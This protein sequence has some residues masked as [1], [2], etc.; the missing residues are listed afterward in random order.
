MCVREFAYLQPALFSL[1]VDY[2]L[3]CKFWS[4]QSVFSVP[5]SCYEKANWKK[6]QH[7][8]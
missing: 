6:L 8:S 3:Y 7:V 4:L 2:A 1:P 5:N